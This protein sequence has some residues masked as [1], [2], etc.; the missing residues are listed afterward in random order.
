MTKSNDIEN[1][2][3]AIR[4]KIYETTQKMS[5]QEKIEY[6]NSHAHEILKQQQLNRIA[7]EVQND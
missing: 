7:D 1:E 3:D 4:D 2:L 5:V 6:I